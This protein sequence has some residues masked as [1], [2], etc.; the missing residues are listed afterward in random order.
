MADSQP[1]AELVAVQSAAEVQRPGQLISDDKDSHIPLIGTW[2]GAV[3]L[4]DYAAGQVIADDYNHC[5]NDGGS[6]AVSG[7]S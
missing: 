3:K 1:T 2:R 4:W 6:H 5:G 7:R